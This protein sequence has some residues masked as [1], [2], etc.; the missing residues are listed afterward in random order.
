MRQGTA[1]WTSLRVCI[2]WCWK[3]QEWVGVIEISVAKNLSSGNVQVN[4]L[5]QYVSGGFFIFLLLFWLPHAYLSLPLSYFI[6][7]YISLV[8]TLS[9]S[10]SLTNDICLYHSS[11]TDCPFLPCNLYC[12]QNNHDIDRPQG[13]YYFYFVIIHLFFFHSVFY[14]TTVNYTHL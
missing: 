4:H 5:A 7:L 8:L 3:K 6:S 13:I 11:Y 12:R 1:K 10:H 14:C 2:F 9:I